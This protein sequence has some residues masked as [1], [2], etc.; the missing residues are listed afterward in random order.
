[1]S[2]SGPGEFT[3]Q[4]G[5]VVDPI[6]QIIDEYGYFDWGWASNH[7][8]DPTAGFGLAFEE[9]PIGIIG[10]VELSIEDFAGNEDY[11]YFEGEI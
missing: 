2:P 6:V 8:F 10:Y 7:S 11:V 9:V 5:S 1:M 4:P 3:P